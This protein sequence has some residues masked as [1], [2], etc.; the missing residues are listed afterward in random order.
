VRGRGQAVAILIT[1]HEAAPF[2][3]CEHQRQFGGPCDLAELIDRQPR[4]PA[5][6]EG[7]EDLPRARVERAELVFDPGV[8]AFANSRLRDRRDRCSRLETVRFG[9]P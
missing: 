6:C 9:P 8:V 1:Y 5:D 3:L 7:G 2:E 4:P